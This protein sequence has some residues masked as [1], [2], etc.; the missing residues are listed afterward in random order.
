MSTITKTGSSVGSNKY[1]IKSG[2]KTPTILGTTTLKGSTEISPGIKLNLQDDLPSGGLSLLKVLFYPNENKKFG[3]KFSLSVN[4][5]QVESITQDSENIYPR[6]EIDSIPSTEIRLM[7][8]LGLSEGDSF[9]T[10]TNSYWHDLTAFGNK[11]IATGNRGTK[12][13]IISSTDGE[14][15]E[16]VDSSGAHDCWYSAAA[17]GANGK[18]M[19]VGH[20]WTSYNQDKAYFYDED[21]NSTYENITNMVNTMIQ[22]PGDHLIFSPTRASN[23]YFRHSIDNGNN[24]TS[25]LQSGASICHKVIYGNDGVDRILV[26]PS[27]GVSTHIYMYL[28]ES[29][30]TSAGIWNLPEPARIHCACCNDQGRWLA[31]SI[32]KDST[33]R[34]YTRLQGDFTSVPSPEGIWYNMIPYQDGFLACSLDGKIARINSDLSYEII[35][36]S[37]DTLEQWYDLAWGDNT[38]IVIGGSPES[39]LRM[40]VSYDLESWIHISTDKK[41]WHSIIYDDKILDAPTFIVFSYDGNEGGV[42]KQNYL[43]MLEEEDFITINTRY[44]TTIN[45]VQTE[46]WGRSDAP[47]IQEDGFRALQVKSEHDGVS[48]DSFKQNSIIYAKNYE[49]ISDY[50]VGIIYSYC[51]GSPTPQLLDSINSLRSST[52]TPEDLIGTYQRNNLSLLTYLTALQGGLHQLELYL[53]SEV[54]SNIPTILTPF[55]GKLSELTFDTF[56]PNELVLQDEVSETNYNQIVLGKNGILDMLSRI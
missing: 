35:F 7:R 6:G 4:G 31:M 56:V 16:H 2:I 9:Q 36:Q 24:W 47:L 25:A 19:A 21:G 18:I 5:V 3:Y 42:S 12:N 27:D 50:V 38:L 51:N 28:T 20:S 45:G 43:S 26:F 17:D 22:D 15:W 10:R 53:L 13:P 23:V 52:P 48:M 11:F 32:D 30:F 34:M 54:D 1:T 49:M 39:N 40:L 33:Q 41:A 44:Y 37:E 46:V 14:N 8:F 29:N 55:K